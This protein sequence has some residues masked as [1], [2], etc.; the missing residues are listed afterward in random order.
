VDARRG[1]TNFRAQTK[2][3]TVAES[4]RRVVED[5]RAIDARNELV[6]RST[7]C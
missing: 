6:G 4:S 1:N 7:G 2:S 5:A 3:E